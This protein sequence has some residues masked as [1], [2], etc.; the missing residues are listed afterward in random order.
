MSLWGCWVL[1]SCRTKVT[2]LS[3]HQKG[4][5]EEEGTGHVGRDL[6]RVPAYGR[7]AEP[8]LMAVCELSWAACVCLSSRALGLGLAV[9]AAPVPARSPA[10]SSR[11]AGGR[12]AE[13]VC[14]LW[15]PRGNASTAL[16][17]HHP[18]AAALRKPDTNDS[19]WLGYLP[20]LSFSGHGDEVYWP[21]YKDGNSVKFD[22]ISINKKQ[23]QTFFSGFT[24][25]KAGQV[26]CILRATRSEFAVPI[27]WLLWL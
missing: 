22:H 19:G 11:A 8:R 27:L 20:Q 9:A 21:K 24:L 17:S 25:P 14:L 23:K 10:A 2:E 7:P 18:V 26:T 12:S 5:Q 6:Q 13:A 16:F 4:F 1:L 3:L 15:L